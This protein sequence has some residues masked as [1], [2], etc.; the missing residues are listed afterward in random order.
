MV[1]LLLAAAH[2]SALIAQK[3]GEAKGTTWTVALKEGTSDVHQIEPKEGE[4][5]QVILTGNGKSDVDLYLFDPD[6][7]ELAKDVTP[8]PDGFVT[9]KVAKNGKHKVELRNLGPGACTSTVLV[10][11]VGGL[12]ATWTVQM[13]ARRRYTRAVSLK[14]G[15]KAVAMLA[16]RNTKCD[17]DLFVIHQNKLVGE[18]TTVGPN[19]KVEFTAKS[20]GVYLVA[21]RN[22]S[23]EA[24]V[25]TVEVRAAD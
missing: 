2:P 11:K 4:Q 19:G 20:A 6:G 22:V 10:D 5:V 21:I 1:A 7:K 17:V 9:F 3:E 12:P 23:N 13:P 8:G 18:D 24:D 16:G 15:Q 25:S 14:E